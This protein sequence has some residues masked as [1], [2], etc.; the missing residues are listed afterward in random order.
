MAADGDASLWDIDEQLDIV[1][2]IRRVRD[3]CLACVDLAGQELF[4]WSLDPIS[5]LV[6]HNLLVF[7]IYSLIDEQPELLFVWHSLSFLD[8]DQERRICLDFD[9]VVFAA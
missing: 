8:K 2:S 3:D 9:D 7:V 4:Y 6:L 5:L 1:L